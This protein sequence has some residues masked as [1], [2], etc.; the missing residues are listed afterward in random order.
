MIMSRHRSPMLPR[1]AVLA[2][3]AVF[4]ASA[5]AGAAAAA[6]P[7]L[8]LGVLV[9]GSVQWVASV[10]LRHGL[11]RAQGF[12]LQTQHIANNDTARVALLGGSADVV[13]SD[14]LFVGAERARGIDLRFAVFSSAT[15]ALVLARNSPVRSFRD[16]AG[17]RLGVAGGPYDKSWMIVRAVARRKE[18]IDLARTAHIAYGAPPLL[19]AKLQQGG[20][21]AVL[22]YWN[23]VAPLEVAG[24]S[25]L[26][27]VSACA[28]DLG[29]PPHPPILGYVFNGTWAAANA[30]LINGFLA[31]SAK[32]EAILLHSDAEWD[33]VRPL[34]N[35]PNDALF[36]RLRDG[37]RAGIAHAPPAEVEKAADRLFAILHAEGGDAATGGLSSMPS[38]V[39]W[40]APS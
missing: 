22:T 26:I 25:P 35:A 2:G 39:F 24:F 1:R 16:L 37:F 6:L 36:L 34:M 13:V 14:W 20:L 19:N 23:Y 30:D 17:R 28:E 21:D 27:T 3:A 38:G 10:I 9:F 18:G 32:A 7:V 31:A 5:G 40:P 4:A 11:D 12:V 33:A 15:G 8:R 29:L